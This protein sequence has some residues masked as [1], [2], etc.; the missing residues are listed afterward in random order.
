MPGQRADGGGPG[1]AAASFSGPAA[2]PYAQDQAEPV[3]LCGQDACLDLLVNRLSVLGL[4][5]V[6]RSYTGCYNSLVA[7]YH[8]RVSMAA[9][10]LRDGETDSYNY[11]FIRRLLPGLPVG[12]FRLA[13][14]ISAAAVNGGGGHRRRRLHPPP[15]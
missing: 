4:G 9:A 12:V 7:L 14:R 15:A 1:G 13:G 11:P 8:G 6:F 10:H 3:I 2:L 5:P